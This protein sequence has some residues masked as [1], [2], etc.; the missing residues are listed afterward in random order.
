MAFR[1]TIKQYNRSLALNYTEKWALGRNPR[2]YDFSN[3]GGDCTNFCSQVL[4]AGGCSMNY[5]HTHGWYYRNG[6]DKSPSWTGVNFL[7]NFL[8]NNKETG[9]FAEQ[10]G[11]KDITTGDIIQLSF[12]EGNIF[13][14]SL[15]VVE[16]GMPVD[17]SNI[18]IS[19][20]TIDR[21][22]YPLANYN[23]TKIRFLHIIGYK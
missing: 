15:V 14:H 12:T 4:H 5:R 23:W 17:I 18:W 13:N 9:P 2:Y 21:Y 22:H 19:T 7:Y 6:N 16:H 3:L 1:T 20:H 10:V 8:I 11:V